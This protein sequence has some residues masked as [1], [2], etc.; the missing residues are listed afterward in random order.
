MLEKKTKKRDG[1]YR[2]CLCWKTKRNNVMDRI[3]VVYVK[4]KMRDM[5]DHIGVIYARIQNER[6]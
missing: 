3:G 5:T 2:C 6:T 1:L 4:N